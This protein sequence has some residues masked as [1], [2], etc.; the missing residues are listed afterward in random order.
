MKTVV[1]MRHAQAAHEPLGER[2]YDRTL[3][4]E[5]RAMA[6]QSALHLQQAGVRIDQ[7]LTSSARRTL[8][9]AQLI[10][11]TICPDAGILA[12][13]ELY[14]AEPSAYVQAMCEQT[15]PGSET[16]LLVGH[17][18]G[19]A[20]L[21]CAWAEDHI[22]VPPATMAVFQLHMTCWSQMTVEGTVQADL[23]QLIQHGHVCL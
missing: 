14:L 16:V 23:L 3:T 15:S 12:L 21:I 18:P 2:D 9:T 1:L 11:Q 20:Q 19:I 17:N 22:S 6:T 7:I 4:P 8:Q 10:A 5:G 13:E